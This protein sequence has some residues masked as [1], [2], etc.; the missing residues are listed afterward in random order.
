M[1]AIAE[2]LQK[3][4]RDFEGMGYALRVVAVLV[5][6]TGDEGLSGTRMWMDE[7]TL[8]KNDR[9]L[10]PRLTVVK[11]DGETPG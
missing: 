5:D 6:I 7:Q 1:P 10:A 4:L 8:L 2:R 3:G 9:E 11:N